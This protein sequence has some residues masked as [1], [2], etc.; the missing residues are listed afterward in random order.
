MDEATSVFLNRFVHTY[1]RLT[2]GASAL[3]HHKL[4][5]ILKHNSIILANSKDSLHMANVR[6]GL[7]L[8]RLY[9]VLKAL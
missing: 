5:P 4:I 9:S 8:W 7:K 3:L 6:G 1:Q 2:G